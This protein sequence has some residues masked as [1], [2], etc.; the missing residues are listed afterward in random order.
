MDVLREEQLNALVR[1]RAFPNPSGTAFLSPACASAFGE[2]LAYWAESR[3][4]QKAH[5]WEAAK[6]VSC[7]GDGGMSDWKLPSAAPNFCQTGT[8]EPLGVAD[9][10]KLVQ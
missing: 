6:L 7:I 10:A 3:A 8:P 9:L 5:L 4:A 1:L 2:Y